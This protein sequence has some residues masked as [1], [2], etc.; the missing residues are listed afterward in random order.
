MDLIYR[1]LYDSLSEVTVENTTVRSISSAST[2]VGDMS[3]TAPSKLT[4]KEIEAKR[5]KARHLELLR[6]KATE[7]EH[8]EATTTP[9]FTMPVVDHIDKQ[10]GKKNAPAF[11][12]YGLLAG[13]VS[14]KNLE[15]GVKGQFAAPKEDPRVFFNIAS[16]SSTF[17][18]GSQGSGKSHTLS[19]L[20]E[21]ALAAS[22]ASNLPHPLT[23]LVFHY[24][25]FISD[26]GGSPCEA[27]FLASNKKIK[28]R[29]LCAPTN[30][31]TIKV[32][33]NAENSSILMDS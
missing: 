8:H 30:V 14:D 16:P 4:P 24:D 9:I 21:N 19:C 28:V 12:Q 17:I 25:T 27:A 20:L 11:P 2:R 6:V 31:A 18:C 10:Q 15:T 26:H 3:D 5:L 32:R 1:S 22:D 23:A 13:T 7:Q 33:L 29:V